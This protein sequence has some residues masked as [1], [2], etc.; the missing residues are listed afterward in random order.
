VYFE[1][2]GPSVLEYQAATRKIDSQPIQIDGNRGMK[3][4][5]GRERGI[6][7]WTRR[8]SYRILPAI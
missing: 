7:R 6:I 2:N 5:T 3:D 8:R 1:L 4:A